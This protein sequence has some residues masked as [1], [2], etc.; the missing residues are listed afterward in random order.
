M[1]L[2]RY[3]AS[4]VEQANRSPCA[5]SKRGVVLWDPVTNRIV[6]RGH[7]APPVGFKCDGSDA[8]RQACGKLCTH[9]EVNAVFSAGHRAV[10][11]DMLHIK[12]VDGQPVPSG[13]P[14]CWQCSRNLISAGVRSCSPE[15]G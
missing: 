8:C 2:D 7:N 14:S 10:K 3:V 5:K 13:P 4:A 1:N 11:A 15:P 12:T 6:G 9:A